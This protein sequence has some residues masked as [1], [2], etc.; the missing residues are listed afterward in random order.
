RGGARHP[1]RDREKPHRA[2]TLSPEGG[3][4]VS[5]RPD[6]ARLSEAEL[7]LLISRSI[8]GDLAPEEQRELEDYLATHPEAMAR[9]AD[10]AELVSLLSKLPAA[11]PPFAL[12]TRVSSQVAERS[13]GLGAVGHR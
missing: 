5:A 10:T 9:H 6:L 8:D 11:E 7:D 13:R 4:F 12:A 1:D 3:A 2:G